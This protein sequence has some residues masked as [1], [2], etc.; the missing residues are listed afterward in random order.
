M[1]RESEAGFTLIELL[2]ALVLLILAVA[3]A[4]QLF[5]ESALQLADATAEQ[6]DP[7][8]PLLI[9]RLRGDVLASSGFASCG[10]DHLELT[11]HPAGT[12][13]YERIGNELHREVFDAT[14]KPLGQSV[15]WRGVIAW[16]CAP[17]GFRLLRLDL[18]YRLRAVRRSLNAPLPG[19]RG[20]AYELRTETFFLTPR[21]A[22]LGE[23]W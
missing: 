3:L 23:S 6:A 22:G 5:M 12:V 19:T 15:P 1:A 14:G 21:G 10:V 8:V 11:G 17:A 13:L 20:D 4:S 9:D 16:S 7:T 18:A 2:V